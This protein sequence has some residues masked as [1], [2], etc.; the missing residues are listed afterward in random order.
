MNIGIDIDDT[1]TN[2]FD[3]LIPY[4]AEYF[5]ANIEY[6]RNNNISYCNLPEEW[7]KR[8]LDFAQKYYDNIIVDT[9]IKSCACEYIRKIKELGHNI[10]IITARDNT[11]YKDAYKKTEEQLNKNNI[12]YDKLI[13][14]FDKGKACLDEHID[15][16]IDDSIYNCK[17][18]SKVGTQAIL[19]NSKSNINT[20]TDFKRV[21]DWKEIY[22]YILAM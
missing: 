20:D 18:V 11:L 10:F 21:N 2:T 8:E 19:F 16:M 15:L 12:Y 4:V 17:E 7:K 22:E 13:C 6:L 3:Y 14:D 9:P 5:G 1:I